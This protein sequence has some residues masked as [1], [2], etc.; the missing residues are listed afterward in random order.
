MIEALAVFS[1]LIAFISIARMMARCGSDAFDDDYEPPAP[2]AAVPRALLAKPAN[3][4]T[5]F[6]VDA[7]TQPAARRKRQQEAA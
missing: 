1:A 3:D 6:P 7:E 5:P 4:V 2:I